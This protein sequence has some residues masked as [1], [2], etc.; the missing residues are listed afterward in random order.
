MSRAS[1][2]LTVIMN[3][4]SQAM[5]D[6]AINAGIWNPTA[7]VND[8]D[9]VSTKPPLSASEG[10]TTPPFDFK[11]LLLPAGLLLGGVILLKMFT[12]KKK[13]GK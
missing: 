10:T 2:L 4:N 6:A 7:P 9:M 13:K 1:E 11:V 5:R 8:S 3:N 12:G